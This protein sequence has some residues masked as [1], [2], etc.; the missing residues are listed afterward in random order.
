MGINAGDTIINDAINPYSLTI[1]EYV[2]G[3]GQTR[4][5]LGDL[6]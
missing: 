6:S 4:L 5:V 1:G 3:S 2:E